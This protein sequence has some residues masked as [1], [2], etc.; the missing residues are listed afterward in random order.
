MSN[1][2]VKCGAPTRWYDKKCAQCGATLAV[3]APTT[4]IALPDFGVSKPR[5]NSTPVAARPQPTSE[6]ESNALDKPLASENAVS[7][8][9]SREEKPPQQT[10]A[11]NENGDKE[12]AAEEEEEEEETSRRASADAAKRRRRAER[13]ATLGRVADVWSS[14]FLSTRTSVSL[15]P[16]Q[17]RRYALWIAFELVAC[18]PCAVLGAYFLTQ[19]LL[20]DRRAAY[21]EAQRKAKQTRTTLFAGLGVFAASL[22]AFMF[23]IQSQQTSVAPSATPNASLFKR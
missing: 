17:V 10:L 15:A 23:Y 5:E 14:A 20:A 11:T 21:S 19:A 16:S 3:V 18:P 7:L 6:P 4:P 1:K 2:C 8:V 9:A 13:L 22:C 12:A